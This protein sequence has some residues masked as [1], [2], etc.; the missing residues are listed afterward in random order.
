[1]MEIRLD[2]ARKDR[3]LDE[4]SSAAR[5]IL[6]HGISRGQG[7]PFTATSSTKPLTK[8]S[9]DFAYL[10]AQSIADIQDEVGKREGRETT[11]TESP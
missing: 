11:C 8:D 7:R 1:M 5:I 6:E 10:Y 4:A 3:R 2:P 9:Q